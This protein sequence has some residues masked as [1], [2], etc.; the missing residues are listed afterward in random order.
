MNEQP[1]TVSALSGPSYNGGHL[2]LGEMKEVAQEQTKCALNLGSLAPAPV[3]LPPT[4][5]SEHSQNTH[6]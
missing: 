2:R 3:R 4:P 1:S 6:R 5:L